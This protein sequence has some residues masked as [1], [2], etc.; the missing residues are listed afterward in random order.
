[1]KK[2]KRGRMN[3]V[4]RNYTYI[5]DHTKYKDAHYDHFP[6]LWLLVIVLFMAFVSY[7]VWAIVTTPTTTTGDPE[8]ARLNVRTECVTGEQLNPTLGTC[9]PINRYP[10]QAEPLIIDKDTSPCDSFFQHSCGL[11]NSEHT[12]ENRAF[13]AVFR[14]NNHII[15]EVI[16]GASTGSPIQTLY[17]SCVETIVQGKHKRENILERDHVRRKILDDFWRVEDLP[18]VLGKL[19]YAGYT[20]P[21]SV[22]IERHPMDNLMI[23]LLRWD[24]FE[25]IT[26]EMVAIIFTGSGA[27]GYLEANAK[28]SRF[29]KVQKELTHHRTH[30][31]DSITSYVEYLDEGVFEQ[32][33]WIMSE[34]NKGEWHWKSFLEEIDGTA[35]G[36]MSNDE[37]KVWCPEASYIRWFSENALTKFTVQEWRDW[38]EFSILYHTHDYVPQLSDNSY[39]KD[40]EWAPVG[41]TAARTIPHIL[42]RRSNGSLKGFS[43]DDCV[44]LTHRLLPGH[45]SQEYLKSAFHNNAEATRKRVQHLGE[46]IRDHVA[47]LID[48]S[49]WLEDTTRNNLREKVQ[50]IIVRAVHPNSWDPEQFGQP[51]VADRYLLNLNIIRMWRVRQNVVLWSNFVSN[52]HIIDR[53]VITRFGAPLSTVNAF[54]SPTSNTIT[55]FAGI[56]RPP[57]YDDNYNTASV[58]ASIGTILAH[59]F[60]HSVD[61]SGSRFDSKGNFRKKGDGWISDADVERFTQ[62]LQCIIDEYNVNDLHVDCTTTSS[63]RKK[64][65]SKRDA[66][67]EQTLGENIADI[68]GVRAAY[69]TFLTVS[70][71]TEKS[72][73][74][75]KWFWVTFA[76]MWCETYDQE[77]ICNRVKN[78]EHSVSLFRVDKTLRNSLHF[79]RD[80]NCVPNR[81]KMARPEHDRCILYGK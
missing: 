23:P 22:S 7:I 72:N 3:R 10:I 38:V 51:L 61:S 47:Q 25:T 9:I 45:V 81:D 16:M 67:G 30:E 56:L 52:D 74:A 43:T 28:V 11:W 37:Q 36:Y 78:D 13:G 50:S 42:K 17:Q 65:I 48:E 41:P 62:R 12:N 20:T 14:E 4:R 57:F 64:T 5:A 79:Q 34:F 6:G 60:S 58:L 31:E 55:I 33:M 40:H 54:Y 63:K 76:Q 71:T 44:K 46:L 39:F 15:K 59:E 21:I 32:H 19:A 27:N 68:V 29:L 73:S 75:R 8:F 49:E 80:Y 24:G 70:N 53:D 2:L 66:Y 26:D 69:E 35:L 77:H 1:M 18:S